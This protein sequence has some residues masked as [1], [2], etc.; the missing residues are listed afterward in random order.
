[1]KKKIKKIII[2]VVIVLLLLVLAFF[3]YKSFSPE[4]KEVK[5]T[6]IV[7]KIDDYGY[8]LKENKPKAY[9]DMFK[10]LEDILKEDEVDEEAYVKK[11]SE[12]FIYDF[13]SLNDKD[14]KTDIGG[15]DFVYNGILENFLQNA[16]NTFYKYVESNIYGNRTQK[17]PIVKDIEIKECTQAPFAY[18]EKTDEKAY[19]VKVSWDYTDTDFSTYQK[20]A[21]LKFIHDGKKLSLVELQ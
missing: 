6:K 3:V 13:Y 21:T 2:G 20:T 15:V 11:I 4:Q 18:G 1:M 10:E 8:K 7:S 5:E 17:L 19:S 14:A 9:K 12:M 16:Q